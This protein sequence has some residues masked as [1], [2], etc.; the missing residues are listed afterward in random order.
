M[1][2]PHWHIDLEPEKAASPLAMS[3]DH[4]ARIPP[5]VNYIHGVVST[6][7]SLVAYCR[8]K[9]TEMRENTSPYYLLGLVTISSS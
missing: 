3:S 4:F 1:M 9:K 5:A 8:G 2:E 7:T 6:I